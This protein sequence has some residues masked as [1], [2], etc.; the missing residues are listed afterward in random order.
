MSLASNNFLYL[1]LKLH[2]GFSSSKFSN[3][4]DHRTKRPD[5]TWLNSWN[6]NIIRFFLET[7]ILAS[8]CSPESCTQFVSQQQ[9]LV[10]LEGSVLM[11]DGWLPL[12]ETKQRSQ[13]EF[14]LI[15]HFQALM[16]HCILDQNTLFFLPWWDKISRLFPQHDKLNL[17]RSFFKYTRKA[18]FLSTDFSIYR[19]VSFRTFPFSLIIS[20][21]CFLAN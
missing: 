5:W 19:C 2:Y 3:M 13:I 17:C 6:S 18:F 10:S 7:L 20:A 11:A 21:L 9:H 16:S 14:S 15:S 4:G 12:P 8:V 1:L